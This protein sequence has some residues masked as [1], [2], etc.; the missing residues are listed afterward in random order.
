MVCIRSVGSL[1]TMHPP[2]N[3]IKARAY[4]RDSRSAAV[5]ANASVQENIGESDITLSGPKPQRFVVADGQLKNIAAAAFPAVARGGSG[6]FNV[7]Y[8]ASIERMDAIDNTYTIAKLPGGF[9]VRETSAVAR[10][11]RPSEPILLYDRQN[12]GESRKVREAVSLLDL[13]TLFR[14]CPAGGQLWLT[15]VGSSLPTMVDPNSGVKIAG[16]A[17]DIVAYLFRTY[18]NRSLPLLLRLPFG[19]TALTAKVGLLPR[20]TAGSVAAP[21]TASKSM[22][23]L[24]LWAYEASPFCVVVREALCELEVPHVQISVARGSPR[25]QILLDRVGHFQVPFLEDPNTGVAMFESKDI[26]TYLW[27]TYGGQ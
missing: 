19:L 16:N 22:A 2:N 6:A 26:V 11:P 5:Q 18:G 27:K 1:V 20:G 25:R 15:E 7:G 4:W 21:T 14:P 17:D 3:A 12:D 24:K 13:D 9:R 10:F 8:K 23:P